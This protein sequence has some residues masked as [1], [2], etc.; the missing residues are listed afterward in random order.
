[1]N[2]QVKRRGAKLIKQKGGGGFT[3]HLFPLSFLNNVQ[4]KGMKVT[5]AA[6]MVSTSR[7]EQEEQIWEANGKVLGISV[8]LS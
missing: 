7:T 8:A 1:M 4:M 5:Q 6:G 2:M 3:G